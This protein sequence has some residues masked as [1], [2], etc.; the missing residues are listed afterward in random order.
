MQIGDKVKILEC[1]SIPELV[2]KTGK[3]MAMA[4]PEVSKYTC[5]VML[6]EAIEMTFEPVDGFKIIAKTT[7]P[8][9]FREDELVLETE[10]QIPDEFKQAFEEGG[11]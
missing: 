10:T 5:I 6:L 3:I 4:S 8:F 11:E 2:G 1:H 7:G 9:P